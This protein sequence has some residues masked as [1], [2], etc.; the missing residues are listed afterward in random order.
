MDGL[1]GSDVRE[2]KWGTRKSET[3]KRKTNVRLHYGAG[4]QCRWLVPSLVGT[5]WGVYRGT[6]GRR[7]YPCLA[8][9]LLWLRVTP[10][11][12]NTFTL[13]GCT[14]VNVKWALAVPHP[15]EQEK[16]SD[17]KQRCLVQAWGVHCQRRAVWNLVELCQSHELR[18]RGCEVVSKM[19][20]VVAKWMWLL[21]SRKSQQ[22][23]REMNK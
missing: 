13:L 19:S 1:F 11:S 8:P 6:R 17:R 4:H 23:K 2:H 12:M 10:K 21:H 9:G 14:C 7:I 3:G 20:N 22:C 5:F 15:G 18:L 16:P